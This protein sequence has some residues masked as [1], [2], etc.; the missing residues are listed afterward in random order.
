MRISDWS[1]DVCSSD[2]VLGRGRGPAAVRMDP[3]HDSG[4]RLVGLC[5]RTDACGLPAG[6]GV[7]SAPVG[8]ARRV[9][10][11]GAPGRPGGRRDRTSVVEGKSVSGR[12][13]RGGRRTIKKTTNKKNQNV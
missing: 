12:V 3:R 4:L 2:L 5:A 11:G 10:A 8:R 6:S 9:E 7:G 1:S 13:E